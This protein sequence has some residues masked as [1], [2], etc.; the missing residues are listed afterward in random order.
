METFFDRWERLIRQHEKTPHVEVEIRL[1]KI[2][3]GSF[4]TNITKETYERVL[5]RL[6]KYDGWERIEESDTSRFYYEGGRRATYDNTKD[7]ITE[8]VTKSRVL[9]D[10]APLANHP[11]DVR[12]GI[13]KEIPCDHVEDEEYTKT[14]NVKRVSFIRKNLRIDVSAVSGD[15]D[16]LDSEHEVEYQVELELMHVPQERHELYNMV[17]KVFD[18]LK[19]VG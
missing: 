13:S 15:P 8:C 3:R 2:N 19:I 16:D 4:D 9:V 11:F 1:G 14:R 18:V 10:D 17:Y 12:L 5:R 6:K 7:D